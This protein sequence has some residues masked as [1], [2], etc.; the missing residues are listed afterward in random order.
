M[1]IFI[2]LCI[3]LFLLLSDNILTD[4]DHRHVHIY[5]IKGNTSQIREQELEWLDCNTTIEMLSVYTYDI[6]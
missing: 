6:T 4:K 2:G 3:L 5:K 1:S